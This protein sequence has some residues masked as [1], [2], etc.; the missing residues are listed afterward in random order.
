MIS[1]HKTKTWA[2]NLLFSRIHYILLSYYTM[3]KCRRNK[4]VYIYRLRMMKDTWLLSSPEMK[5]KWDAGKQ[6]SCE[7][8]H[9]NMNIPQMPGVFFPVMGWQG[10]RSVSAPASSVFLLTP[11]VNSPIELHVFLNHRCFFTVGKHTHVHVVL[12]QCSLKPPRLSLPRFNPLW[13]GA[14]IYPTLSQ[15]FSW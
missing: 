7:E 11:H 13:Q 2:Y 15:L 14:L 12:T 10:R 8:S 4:F 9:S 5:H 1:I 6:H 3:Y